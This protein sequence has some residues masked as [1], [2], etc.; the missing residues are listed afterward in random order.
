MP[1]RNRPKN[2]NRSGRRKQGAQPTVGRA[3]MRAASRR[4][5]NG[6][7]KGRQ[8][9]G[10]QRFFRQADGEQGEAGGEIVIL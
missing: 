4:I 8:I 7:G 5:E 2:R 1:C 10:D 9:V 6:I 3:K